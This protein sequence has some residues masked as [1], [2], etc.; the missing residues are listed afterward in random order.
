MVF[1]R[2]LFRNSYKVLFTSYNISGRNRVGV[3]ETLRLIF[4]RKINASR[5][6]LY[7]Y[8]KWYFSVI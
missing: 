8:E 2:I 6:L 7:E 4:E 1:Q 3:L 5:L